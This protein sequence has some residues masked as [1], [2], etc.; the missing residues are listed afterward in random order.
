MLNLIFVEFYG[1]LWKKMEGQLEKVRNKD[2]I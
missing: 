2:I 1:T